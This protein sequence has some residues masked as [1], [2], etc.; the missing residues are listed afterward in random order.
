MEGTLGVFVP[1]KDNVRNLLLLSEMIAVRIQ[2]AVR[3]FH[4]QDRN[5]ISFQAD[6]PFVV[7]HKG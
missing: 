3:V 7:L 2:P 4:L 5:L 6:L 1:D